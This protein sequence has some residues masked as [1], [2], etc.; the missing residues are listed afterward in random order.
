MSKNES[1]FVRCVK[2]DATIPSAEVGRHTDM[3]FINISRLYVKYLCT[4]IKYDKNLLY[5]QNHPVCVNTDATTPIA[6]VD[7]HTVYKRL[8]FVHEIPI[9]IY[10]IYDKNI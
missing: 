5:V 3:Q 6:D 4:H 2:I 9:H 10:E 8:P 7:R 1:L